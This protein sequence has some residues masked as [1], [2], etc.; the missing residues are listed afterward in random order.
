M[1]LYGGFY[2]ETIKTILEALYFVKE[3]VIRYGKEKKIAVEWVH[4]DVIDKEIGKE[5]KMIEWAETFFKEK[6]G[7]DVY[8]MDAKNHEALMDITRSALEIYLRNTIEAK[9]KSGLAGFDAKIQEI[10]RIISL[11]GLKDRKTDLYDKYYEAPI[12][13]AEGEKIEVFL[14][15]SHEDRVLAGEI[16]RLLTKRGIDVFL[17]HED[18]EVSEEWREE[19]FEHLESC[20]VLVALLTPNF[21]KSVWA[22]QEAGHMRGKGGKVIPLIVGE[23]DIKKFGFLEALQGIPVK[24]NLDDCVE[25]ILKIILK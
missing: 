19:I 5:V 10:R 8:D 13:A 25:E 7:S 17:A 24:E 6:A 15:Y 4:H 11:E 21:E 1:P 18:I 22:N 2:P 14:S 20:I 12:P 9:A 3:R 16:A 23:T